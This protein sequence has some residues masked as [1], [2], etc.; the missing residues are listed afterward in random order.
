[1]AEGI[2]GM[3]GGAVISPLSTNHLPWKGLGGALAMGLD[4]VVNKVGSD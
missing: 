3:T 4:G 2:P 1:M